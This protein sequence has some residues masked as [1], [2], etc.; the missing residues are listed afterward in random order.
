MTLFPPAREEGRAFKI[1]R[2]IL[3]EPSAIYERAPSASSYDGG[4]TGRGGLP[5]IALDRT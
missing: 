3:E 1:A 5:P 2:S 4:P